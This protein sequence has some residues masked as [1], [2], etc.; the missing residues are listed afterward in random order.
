MAY[1]CKKT[2]NWYIYIF[3]LLKRCLQVVYKIAFN[4]L[5]NSLSNLVDMYKVYL[6]L[7]CI[8]IIGYKMISIIL[9]QSMV[10]LPATETT[11]HSAL[12]LSQ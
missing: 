2:I 12:T 4:L 9:A 3:F 1:N 11:H 6:Q 10:I 8:Q 7:T 5:N